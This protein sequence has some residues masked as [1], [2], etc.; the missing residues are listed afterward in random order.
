MRWNAAAGAAAACRGRRESGEVRWPAPLRGAMLRGC[1]AAR[2]EPAPYGPLRGRCANIIVAFIVQ[3]GDEGRSTD[4]CAWRGAMQ[5]AQGQ[6][7]R[8]RSRGGTA[9]GA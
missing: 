1:H 8:E 5:G 3:V 9:G 7:P 6:E 2:R 4:C